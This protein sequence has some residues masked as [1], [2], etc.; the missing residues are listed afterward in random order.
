MASRLWKYEP[1]ANCAEPVTVQQAR[2]IG[3]DGGA[4]PIVVEA[5]DEATAYRRASQWAAADGHDDVGDLGL[6]WEKLGG[7]YA[8]LVEY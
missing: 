7:V 8:V 4:P 3:W 5:P 1:G 2:A 6:D